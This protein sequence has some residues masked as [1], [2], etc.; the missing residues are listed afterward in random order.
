MVSKTIWVFL[1]AQSAFAFNTNNF[2]SREFF[3]GTAI[4]TDATESIAKNKAMDQARVE[5]GKAI[6][7]NVASSSESKISAARSDRDGKKNE[8]LQKF[9]TS[10]S[11]V[12]SAVENLSD[13]ETM[14]SSYNEESGEAKVVLVINRGEYVKKHLAQIKEIGQSIKKLMEQALVDGSGIRR[15]SKLKNVISNYDRE[16]S[17]IEIYNAIR[18]FDDPSLQELIG[19]ERIQILEKLTLEVEKITAS[20]ETT[21][22]TEI[23][24]S[25]IK[26][27]SDFGIRSA[28][29]GRLKFIV[30]GSIETIPDSLMIRKNLVMV[31]SSL[32]V[33]I[34]ENGEFITSF[35]LVADEANES[36]KAAS[37]RA[38]AALKNKVQEQ[39]IEKLTANY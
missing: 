11:R 27:L 14:E 2:P 17:K 12:T 7:A 25:V 1:F 38:F 21:G 15:I 26:S 32:F 39:F 6:S 13:M 30:K 3:V 4:Y 37:M 20:V 16:R 10:S 35:E 34:E 22:P 31:R 24:D 33:R 28:K 8:W 19:W 29:D 36:E 23:I 5:L 18:R 9:Y